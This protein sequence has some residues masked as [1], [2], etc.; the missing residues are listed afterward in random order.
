MAS[1][2]TELL[3]M[4]PDFGLYGHLWRRGRMHGETELAFKK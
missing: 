4:R 1:G 2:E 3:Q